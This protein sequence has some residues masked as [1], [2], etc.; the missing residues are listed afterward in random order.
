MKNVFSNEVDAWN[1]MRFWWFWRV[2]PAAKVLLYGD[3]RNLSFTQAPKQTS[4]LLFQSLG[5]Q[6]QALR[7]ALCKVHMQDK[8]RQRR[9]L[10]KWSSSGFTHVSFPHLLAYRTSGICP[11]KIILCRFAPMM[12]Y[13]YKIPCSLWISHMIW[14][15]YE[16]TYI[17]TVYIVFGY[18]YPA[19]LLSTQF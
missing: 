14:Y 7:M 6:V 8:A 9:A 12:C 19:Y 11:P 1:S 15:G 5:D 4:G 13:V 18:V 10:V 17:C 16:S 2:R 3:W